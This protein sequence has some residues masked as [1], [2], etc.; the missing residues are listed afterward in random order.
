MTFVSSKINI[1][2]LLAGFGWLEPDFEID[3]LIINL[4]PIRKVF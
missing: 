2:F 1:Y 3:L 4:K